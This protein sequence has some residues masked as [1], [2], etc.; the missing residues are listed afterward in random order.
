MKRRAATGRSAL[1][2]VRHDRVWAATRKGLNQPT[3]T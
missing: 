1:R 2:M 3:Y